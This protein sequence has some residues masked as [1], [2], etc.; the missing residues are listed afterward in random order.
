M[1]MGV[2]LGTNRV[3]RGREDGNGDG[4]GAVLNPRL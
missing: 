4:D 1:V 3:T 2:E